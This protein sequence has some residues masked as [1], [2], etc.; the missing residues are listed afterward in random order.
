MKNRNTTSQ[1]FHLHYKRI[2]LATST[3]AATERGPVAATIAATAIAVAIRRLAALRAMMILSAIIHTAS[4]CC[5]LA[6]ICYEYLPTTS[7]AMVP[8]ATWFGLGS[9]FLQK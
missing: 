6:D 4:Y 5:Y 9:G 7:L 3:C 2:I 8:K 1:I